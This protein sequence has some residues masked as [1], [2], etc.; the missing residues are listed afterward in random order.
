MPVAYAVA[1]ITVTDQEKYAEY[2]KLAGPAMA[3]FGGKFLVRGGRTAVLEG[4]LEHPRVALLEFPSFEKAQE[5]YNSP[6]YAAARA[7]REGAA[8]FNFVLVEGAA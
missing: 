7:K 2:M 8:V 4:K 5:F 3:K 6:E 1:T